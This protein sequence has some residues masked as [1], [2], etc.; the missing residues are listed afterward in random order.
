MREL[1]NLNEA[2]GDVLKAF[3]P[4][5]LACGVSYLTQGTASLQVTTGFDTV[6]YRVPLGVVAG[7]CPFNFP[8]MIPWG[9]MAPLCIATG[10]TLVLKAASYT[11]LTSMRMLELFYEEAGFPKGVV[12]L[13][14]CSRSESKLPYRRTDKSRDICGSTDMKHILLSPPRG[15]CRRSAG[16]KPL[17]LEDCDLEARECCR[18]FDIRLCEDALHG[19]SGYRRAGGIANQFVALLKKRRRRW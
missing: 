4:T 13:V 14:T 19:T 3:E 5:E 18:Q 1:G 9:W 10:N 8:A 16:E 17:V 15:R 6:S 12:N 7:I 11:P 2:R